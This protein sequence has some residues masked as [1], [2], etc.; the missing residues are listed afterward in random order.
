VA[1]PGTVSRDHAARLLSEWTLQKVTG[2]TLTN[3]EQMRVLPPQLRLATRYTSELLVIARC[4]LDLKD[5]GIRNPQN[6]DYV[7]LLLSS[8]NAKGHATVTLRNHGGAVITIS[9]PVGKYRREAREAVGAEPKGAT[10]QWA[11]SVT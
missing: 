5:H 2:Y 4:S 9:V 1:M 7:K 3:L 10:Q 11:G 6:G 8:V